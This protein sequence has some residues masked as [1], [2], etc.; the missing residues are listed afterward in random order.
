MGF[1]DWIKSARN[2]CPRDWIST[3][4]SF[5]AKAEKPLQ[6][7]INKASQNRIGGVPVLQLQS[8]SDTSSPALEA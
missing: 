6:A 2:F 3:T 5:C 8:K 7:K 1:A 4:F